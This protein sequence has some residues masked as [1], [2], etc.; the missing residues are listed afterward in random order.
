M[1]T[2]AMAIIVMGPT[3]AGKSTIGRALAR[4]LGWPYLGA[5]DLHTPEHVRQMQRGV[6]LSDAQR[7]PWLAAISREIR[8]AVSQ[9]TSLVV[10][11]SALKRSYRDA[12]RAAARSTGA[13]QFVY[14]HVSRT[15]LARRV[16]ARAGHFAPPSLVDTQLATLE[17]PGPDEGDVLQVNG[18]QH[19]DVIVNNLTC[20]LKAD[21]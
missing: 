19:V 6:P 21:S 13:V 12:L 14:L 17:E 20:K 9:G 16:G 15:E 8:T 10:S 2:G 18:E 5:D 4:A 1:R 3:G 11:C 7:A